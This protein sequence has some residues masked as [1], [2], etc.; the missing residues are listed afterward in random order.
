MRHAGRVRFGSAVGSGD[1]AP[2]AG[3]RVA[4]PA[5]YGDRHRAA[6][7][8]RGSQS[9]GNH[10]PAHGSD[11]PGPRRRTEHATRRCAGPGRTRAWLSLLRRPR[12]ERTLSAALGASAPPP[13]ARARTCRSSRAGL[14]G[15]LL[16]SPRAGVSA[17]GAGSRS[18]RWVA[19][20]R[21]RRRRRRVRR[22][23]RLVGL[24]LGLVLC[25]LF[26]VLWRRLPLSAMAGVCVWRRFCGGR[27][28]LWPSSSGL[29][30]P[31]GVDQVCLGALTPGPIAR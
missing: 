21:L 22:R 3:D 7:R 18:A 28:L 27:R 1:H 8:K 4:C 14:S 19:V 26:L 17:G 2:V 5:S 25:L 6:G 11:D 13:W 20:C 30:S 29:V 12:P 23:V 9:S 31:F 10:R 24:G 16:L 15:V